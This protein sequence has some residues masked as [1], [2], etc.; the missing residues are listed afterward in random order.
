VDKVQDNISS[1]FSTRLMPCYR[2]KQ[3]SRVS[4]I[5]ANNIMRSMIYGNEKN[6]WLIGLKY[7]CLEKQKLFC[8]VPLPPGHKSSQAIP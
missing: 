4:E 7:V 5:H 8:C 2:D 3:V 1:V 6:N